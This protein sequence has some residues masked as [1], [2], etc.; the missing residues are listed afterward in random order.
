MFGTI[1]KLH[2]EKWSSKCSEYED[3]FHEVKQ[4]KFNRSVVLP[5]LHWPGTMIRVMP[6]A[7]KPLQLMPEFK[8]YLRLHTSKFQP[9][10]KSENNP[11]KCSRVILLSMRIAGLTTGLNWVNWSP[12]QGARGSKGPLATKMTVAVYLILFIESVI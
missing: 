9:I 5:P 3:S 12:C 10:F 1:T 8:L 2:G 6:G 4:E 11:T 7:S